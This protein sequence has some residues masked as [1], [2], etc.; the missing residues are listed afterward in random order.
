MSFLSHGHTAHFCTQLQIA[1]AVGEIDT[2]F[3][4]SRFDRHKCN[5]QIYM[6]FTLQL[7]LG[8]LW[9]ATILLCQSARIGQQRFQKINDVFGVFNA[10]LELLTHQFEALIADVVS[11]AQKAN[12]NFLF[13][14]I[15]RHVLQGELKNRNKHNW[16]AH[17]FNASIQVQDIP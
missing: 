2:K 14:V 15:Q 12:E 6:P 16:W 5:L 8:G 7:C 11:R 1:C 9:R 17:P 3:P 4:P 13:L 10:V